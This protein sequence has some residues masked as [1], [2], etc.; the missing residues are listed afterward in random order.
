MYI[1]AHQGRLMTTNDI[2]F[3]KHCVI[4]LPSRVVTAA[5]LPLSSTMH[6]K[7]YFHSFAKEVDNVIVIVH[8]EGALVA[9]EKR[10]INSRI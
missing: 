8:V 4:L 6:A 7:A 3:Q 2:I 5:F 9:V 1:T 10:A